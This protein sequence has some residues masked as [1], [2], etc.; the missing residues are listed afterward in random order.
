MNEAVT[1]SCDHRFC[2]S[3][4]TDDLNYKI[5]NSMTQEN[6]LIC[7]LDMKPIDFSIIMHLLD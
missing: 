6:M 3:C 4:L 1:L 5:N 7:P 2:G